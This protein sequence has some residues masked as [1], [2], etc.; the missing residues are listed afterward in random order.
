MA[1]P[2]PGVADVFLIPKPSK[3]KTLQLLLCRDTISFI[4]FCKEASRKSPNGHK[5]FQPSTTPPVLRHHT[6]LVILHDLSSDFDACFFRVGRFQPF[7]RGDPTIWS[8]NKQNPSTCIPCGETAQCKDRTRVKYCRHHSCR[9]RIANPRRTNR[10]ACH[11]KNNVRFFI[12]MMNADP[13]Q[14]A[15]TEENKQPL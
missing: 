6:F 1:R 8:S 7:S 14:T 12:C 11:D 4:W 9:P 13:G 5:H 2:L 3:V 15:K 10:N